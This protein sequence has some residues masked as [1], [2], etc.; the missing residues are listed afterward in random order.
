[1]SILQSVQ[2]M[3]IIRRVPALKPGYT[4]RVHQK[5]KEGDKERI[6]IFEGLVIRINSGH[7]ADKTFTVRKV[8]GG[9][10]VEKIYPLHSTIIAKLEIIKTS[11][12][13]RSKLNYL[14]Q[15]F[16][17]SARLKEAFV[18]SEKLESMYEEIPEENIVKEEIEETVIETVE[19]TEESAP[20]AV[21]EKKETEASAE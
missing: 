1:M 7:G 15:R 9:I 2:R 21:E 8:V 12:V 11:K 16:G 10:G 14:R 18:S 3:A 5:I 4:V 19:E 20:E 6:Q 13:R 17:K